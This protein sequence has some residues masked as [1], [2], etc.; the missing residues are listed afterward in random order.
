MSA[1]NA[2]YGEIYNYYQSRY[3]PKTN[4]RFDAHNKS[5][6]KKVYNSI[7]NNSKEKPVYLLDPFERVQ[8]YTI[9]LKESALQF[10]RDIASM[11]GLEGDNLFSHKSAYSSNPEIAS[12]EMLNNRLISDDAPELNIEVQSLAKNQ[13]NTG[14]FLEA[15][16]LG[17][18]NGT[19]SFDVSTSSS[20]YEL[21]FG[22]TDN[23]TNYSIQTRLARLINSAAIGLNA[24]IIDGA[25]NTHALSISS[26]SSGSQDGEAPFE[27]SDE[28]TSQMKGVI[29]YLGIKNVAQKASWAH[30]TVNGEERMSPDNEVVESDAYV[31]SLHGE[32][33]PGENVIVGIKPNYESLR[34]NIVGVANSYNHFIKTAA[35]FIE[36]QPKSGVLINNM[37]RMEN[38]YKTTLERFGMYGTEQG[39]LALNEEKL[40]LALKNT[41][42]DNDVSNLRAFAKSAYRKIS[43]VKLDPMDYVDKRIVAYKNP[44]VKHFANPYLTSAYSGMIFNSYM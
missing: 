42:T 32:S 35:E 29:D 17:L 16:S 18:E 28:N 27:I 20:N 23:D 31:I 15:G 21:Q 14:F 8:D 6:L 19:Y 3:V 7:V 1:L 44:N 2:V 9:A 26:V 37:K 43:H 11:G 22:I 40:D 25:N 13:V 4:S 33:Q 30:Y 24:R 34:E 41:T 36:S 39:E 12:V 10:D 5:D 38:Y